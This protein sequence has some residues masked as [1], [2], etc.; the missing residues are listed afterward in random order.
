MAEPGEWRTWAWSSSW[1][2]ISNIFRA[3]WDTHTDREI[4]RE[5]KTKWI[6]NYNSII[7]YYR[8]VCVRVLDTYHTTVMNV[9]SM[10]IISIRYT[11]TCRAFAM[12]TVLQIYRCMCEHLKSIRQLID[13]PF[14]SQIYS[15][16]STQMLM[17]R[18]KWNEM[19]WNGI[20]MEFRVFA[21]FKLHSK[22]L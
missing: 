7:Y 17:F 9:G 19:K 16:Y 3:F 13:L 21:W 14:W 15:L 12:H 4:E 6:I 1:W 20:S 22:F 8:I 10:Q 18:G 5:P 2:M 11:R